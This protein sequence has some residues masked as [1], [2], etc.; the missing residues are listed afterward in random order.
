VASASSRSSGLGAALTLDKRVSNIKPLLGPGGGLGTSGR[1]PRPGQPDTGADNTIKLRDAVPRHRDVSSADAGGVS[2][3]RAAIHLA[4][5]AADAAR[6]GPAASVLLRG[7]PG[8]PADARDGRR[9]GW[10]ESRA[11]KAHGSEDRRD[12][13]RVHD[14]GD[15]AQ[16]A[17]TLWTGQHVDREGGV[18]GRTT[19]EARAA[20]A[21]GVLGDAVELATLHHCVS[22]Q[23]GAV[24]PPRREGLHRVGPP[25]AHEPV[26]ADVPELRHCVT[27]T[28]SSTLLAV[29]GP[30]AA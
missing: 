6:P 14:G 12:G 21:S 18:D 9:G 2:R 3:G 13:R 29:R 27:E 25:S 19:G 5:R 24:R 15:E 7:G 11:G 16:S 1:S 10:G 4:R 17:A 28:R 23:P 30:A 8:P 20:A 22:W 26:G